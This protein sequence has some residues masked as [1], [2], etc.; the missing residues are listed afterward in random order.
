M[1]SIITCVNNFEEYEKN[2]D[3][4]AELIP[5]DNTENKYDNKKLSRD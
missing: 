5:I 1:I 2:I 4:D 3:I